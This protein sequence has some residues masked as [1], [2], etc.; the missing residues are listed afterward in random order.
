[1]TI[2]YMME[3]ETPA[4]Q[5]AL[6]IPVMVEFNVTAPRRGARD[7]CCGIRGA[8]P[9]LEP[10]EPAEMEIESVID[11]KTGQQVEPDA[12]ETKR[13]EEACW[14]YVNND[15]DVEDYFEDR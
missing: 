4:D 12:D 2:R 13:I 15:V 9:A 11:E 6:E 5:P 3:I 10:D 8:G 14:E 7:S 1:M